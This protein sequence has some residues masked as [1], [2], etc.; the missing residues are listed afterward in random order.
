MERTCLWERAMS[1]Q[2]FSALP[3]VSSL[4][5]LMQLEEELC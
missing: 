3:G 5:E 4:H 2:D 1:W